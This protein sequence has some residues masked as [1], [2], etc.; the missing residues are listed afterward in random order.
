[1]GRPPYYYSL[2]SVLMCVL[3]LEQ[4]D[5][6]LLKIIIIRKQQ[7]THEN[8]SGGNIESGI[9]HMSLVAHKAPDRSVSDFFLLFG[10]ALNRELWYVIRN[11]KKKPA[12]ACVFTLIVVFRSK[13][14]H[15]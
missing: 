9:V 3:L 7:H 15:C 5:Y 10:V 11:Q 2:V 14:C 12:R 1:M 6:S 4:S 13:L 8:T